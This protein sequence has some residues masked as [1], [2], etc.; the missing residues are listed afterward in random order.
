MT[1]TTMR[2]ADTTATAR[3]SVNV[4]R[5]YGHAAGFAANG[6]MA[7]ASWSIPCLVHSTHKPR[8]R[9]PQGLPS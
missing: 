4:A 8:P 6:V 9:R 3:T 2:Q 1:D 7:A 5:A